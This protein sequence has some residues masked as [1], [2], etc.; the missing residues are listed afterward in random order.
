[1][2]IHKLDSL[3]CNFKSE[4]KSIIPKQSNIQ[5][6]CDL[7]AILSKTYCLLGLKK[8]EKLKRKS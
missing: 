7:T 6:T 3:N 4:R 2:Q 1:M 5:H 8:Y